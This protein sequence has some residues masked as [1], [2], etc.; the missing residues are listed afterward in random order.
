MVDLMYPKLKVFKNFI[1]KNFWDNDQYVRKLPKHLKG[2][3][4]TGNK[5]E[6]TP[7]YMLQELFKMCPLEG[8]SLR[9][10]PNG[11]HNDTWFV[12]KEEYFEVID[13]FVKSLF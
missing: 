6:I 11:M 4:L 1:L 12:H 7:T 3:F 13:E 2:L 8:K 5:D 9:Q 10:F